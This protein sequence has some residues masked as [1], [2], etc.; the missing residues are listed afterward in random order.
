MN[1]PIVVE[2]TIPSAH[3]SNNTTAIVHNIPHLPQVNRRI[4][5]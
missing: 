1:P 5:F 3:K 4:S 2:L